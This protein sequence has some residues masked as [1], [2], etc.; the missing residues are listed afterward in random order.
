MTRDQNANDISETRPD[1]ASRNEPKPPDR[2]KDLPE[3]P[4]PVEVG[5]AG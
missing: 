2:S 3:L 4:D 5:E 1:D